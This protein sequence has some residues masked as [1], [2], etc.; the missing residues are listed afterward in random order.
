MFARSPSTPVPHEVPDLR[1]CD[2]SRPGSRAASRFASWPPWAPRPPPASIRYRRLRT[3]PKRMAVAARGWR[4]WRIGGRGRPN[5]ADFLDGVPRAHSLVVNP[6]KWLFTPIDISVFYTREPE[7]LRR[8]FSLIAEYLKTEAG[9]PARVN[10]MDYGVQLGPAF[11]LSEAL[12]RDALFRA[13]RVRADPAQPYRWAQEL[14]GLI[15][16]RS[17]ILRSSPRRPSR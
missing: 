14:A 16:A 6:H 3:L 5:I 10:Y 1:S 15:R 7:I 9:F 12:V 2:R 13:R 4:L 8:A 11:P 17:A